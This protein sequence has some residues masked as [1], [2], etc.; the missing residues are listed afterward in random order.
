MLSYVLLNHSCIVLLLLCV[1]LCQFVTISSC[2]VTF[3]CSSLYFFIL[4]CL[5]YY[6]ILLNCSYGTLLYNILMVFYVLCWC[7]FM[8]SVIQY[9]QFHCR[10]VYHKAVLC[11]VLVFYSDT[12]LCFFNSYSVLLFLVWSL[13]M[14]AFNVLLVFCTYMFSFLQ[15]HQGPLQLH[16]LTPTPV[17]YLI[18]LRPQPT[19]S[20]SLFW[21]HHR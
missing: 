11:H 13:V 21:F 14:L 1:L 10:R 5:C 20:T 7:S 6:I 8:F 3:C 4:F 19:Q 15:R 17:S 2:Y 16:G 9:T 12:T 18:Y